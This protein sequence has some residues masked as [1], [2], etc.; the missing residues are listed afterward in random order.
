[1]NVAG[2][3]A[4]LTAHVAE[5]SYELRQS[6][7]NGG[8]AF[9]RAKTPGNAIPG[10]IRIEGIVCRSHYGSAVFLK[11][12]HSAQAATIIPSHDSTAAFQP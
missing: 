8:A 1:M 5:F 4:P 9:C 2:E 11:T 3:Q 7:R 12:M 10:A 6:L